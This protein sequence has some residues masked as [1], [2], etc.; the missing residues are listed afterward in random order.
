MDQRALHKDL[1]R[2]IIV[3]L[4]RLGKAMKGRLPNMSF[5]TKERYFVLLSALVAKLEASDKSMRDIM[6]E[7]MPKAM[8][9][10]LHEMQG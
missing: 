9:L 3:M 10:I 5:E 2:Q 6:Q 8:E 4:N 1:D 7:M